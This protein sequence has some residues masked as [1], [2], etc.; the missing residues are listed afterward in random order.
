MIMKGTLTQENHIIQLNASQLDAWLNLHQLGIAQKL[1]AFYNP[2]QDASNVQ[3]PVHIPVPVQTTVPVHTPDHIPIAIQ[4]LAVN[5]APVYVP[6]P[7]YKKSSRDSGY[8]KKA[9]ETN[10]SQK[11]PEYNKKPSV[12]YQH[13][14]KNQQNT[15]RVNEVY[16]KRVP[17][18][19]TEYKADR[20]VTNQ[21]YTKV[22]D[23]KTDQQL[24]HYGHNQGY[25]H[26]T[27]F[28]K[29]VSPQEPSNRTATGYPSTQN[30]NA[31]HQFQDIY[32]KKSH[33]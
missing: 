17:V 29:Q 20:P 24:R 31:S 4:T 14:P 27:G 25:S 8:I 21:L 1:L 33:N 19:Q 13:Q 10:H 9:E 23:L 32:T 22:A 3:T 7:E 15:S 6:D 5:L 30:G 11:I 18:S 2:C 16:D 28:S 26:F 12:H